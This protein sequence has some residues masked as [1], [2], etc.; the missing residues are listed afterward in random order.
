MSKQLSKRQQRKARRRA[1]EEANYRPGGPW[2]SIT[3][4]LKTIAVLSLLVAAWTAWQL[5]K[6]LPWWES[7][8]WG[9]GFG[10]S[11]WLVFYLAFRLQVWLRRDR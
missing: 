1:E 9:L 2:L 6:A 10:A 11:I 8:L 7:I 4:G 5:S 3:T